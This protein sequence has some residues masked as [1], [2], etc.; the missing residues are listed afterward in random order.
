MKEINIYS[1]RFSIFQVLEIL[2]YRIFNI[3]EN[4][5]LTATYVIFMQFTI[6]ISIAR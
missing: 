1:N 3:V 6:F 5:I 2:Y 4:F